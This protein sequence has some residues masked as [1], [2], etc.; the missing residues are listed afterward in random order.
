MRVKISKSE[1]RGKVA[2][3]PS[4]SYTI[5]SLMCAA[6][7]KGKSRI[8]NP[9]ISDDT[10]A[11]SQALE[12][13]GIKIQKN[14]GCWEVQGGRFHAP[15]GDIYC[16]FRNHALYGMSFSHY[17]ANAGLFPAFTANVHRAAGYSANKL[18]LNTYGRFGSCCRQG[19]IPGGNVSLT[20]DVSSQFISPAFPV[21]LLKQA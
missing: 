19:Q 3:P 11:A 8:I 6:L 20:G 10:E 7:A 17:P 18:R 5:R 9:L 16:R 12:T 13:V 14:D 15:D 4:K 1:L 21:P 2:V